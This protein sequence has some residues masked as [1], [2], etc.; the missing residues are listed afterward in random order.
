MQKDR[1]WRIVEVGMVAL[2][3]EDIVVVVVVEG[4][5]VVEGN[6]VVVEKV[7]TV[8]VG[9]SSVG[10]EGSSIVV[11]LVEGKFGGSK[12]VVVVVVVVA[13]AVV[14]VVGEDDRTIVDVEV[15]GNSMFV[16]LPQVEQQQVVRR[17]VVVL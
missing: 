15:E 12:A 10:V 4:T 2:N 11:E 3:T 17:Q 7:G 9:G 13:A 6:L 5:L 14:V 8:G 1:H 16:V